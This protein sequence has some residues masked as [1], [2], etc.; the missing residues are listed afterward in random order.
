MRI[1]TAS[2]ARL[3]R[4]SYSSLLLSLALSLLAACGNSSPRGTPGR[5]HAPGA[6][7]P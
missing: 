7:V 1:K 5:A 2:F 6:G 4:C 3:G